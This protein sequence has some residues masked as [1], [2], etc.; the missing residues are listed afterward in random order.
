MGSRGAG[1]VAAMGLPHG[2]LYSVC[3]SGIRRQR[4]PARGKL[5]SSFLYDQAVIGQVCCW[6]IQS[7]SL[8]SG[9]VQADTCTGPKSA[10]PGATSCVGGGNMPASGCMRPC[11]FQKPSHLSLSRSRGH[12]QLWVWGCSP[13]HAW[14]ISCKC[15][16]QAS[17]HFNGISEHQCHSSSHTIYGS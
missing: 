13:S 17:T 11:F 9:R 7:C 16:G 6:S 2:L 14:L 1:V 4:V 8:F 5:T 15:Q 10:L 3:C 12:E